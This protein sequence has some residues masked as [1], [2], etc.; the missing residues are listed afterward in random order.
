[1]IVWY[2]TPGEPSSDGRGLDSSFRLTRSMYSVRLYALLHQIPSVRWFPVSLECQTI[3]G[4]V[5]VRLYRPGARSVLL[6]VRSTCLHISVQLEYSALLANILQYCWQ[7]RWASPIR[8][9]SFTQVPALKP[10][11][12]YWT[13][14]T[15]FHTIPILSF[16]HQ[17]CPLDSLGLFRTTDSLYRRTRPGSYR[18]SHQIPRSRLVAIIVYYTIWSFLVWLSRSLDLQDSIYLSWCRYH[19]NL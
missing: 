1:M 6:S 8:S 11:V 3:G 7:G 10:G 9:F 17:P 4:T 13:A 2:S 12:R 5:Y 16:L 14:W 19:I 18:T 15:M